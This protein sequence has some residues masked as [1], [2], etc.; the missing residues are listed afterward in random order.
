MENQY[1]FWAG[2]V[3]GQQYL[4]SFTAFRAALS[5]ETKCSGAEDVL[6]LTHTFLSAVE[7]YP[8]GKLAFS[9]DPASL[10]IRIREL[11]KRRNLVETPIHHH[12]SIEN[13]QEFRQSCTSIF[14][15]AIPNPGA[16]HLRKYSADE[17]LA[18]CFAILGYI[19]GRFNG[20]PVSG[21]RFDME[22]AVNA[23]L[24]LGFPLRA[25][26]PRVAQM[27]PL[28]AT[29]PVPGGLRPKGALPFVAGNDSSSDDSD[30]E[31]VSDLDD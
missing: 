13:E 22:L 8:L 16:M 19:S 3:S 7:S 10:V 21:R 18:E 23:A 5:D 29:R 20:F 1:A 28:H 24:Q 6:T 26:L 30:F 27:P 17:S 14:A 12:L 9:R 2:V 15:R 11:A 25:E 31:K 4:A